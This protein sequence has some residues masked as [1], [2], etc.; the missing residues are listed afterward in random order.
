MMQLLSSA[1]L[2][3]QAVGQLLHDLLLVK[4]LLRAPARLVAVPDALPQALRTTKT[5]RHPS[6]SGS[7]D[8]ACPVS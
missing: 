3:A 4:V 5:L 8:S 7:V 1:R 2:G 6:F